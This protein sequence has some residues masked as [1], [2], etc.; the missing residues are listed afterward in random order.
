MHVHCFTV[1]LAIL[2][3]LSLAASTYG[4]DVIFEKDIEYAQ[5]GGESLKLNLARP[6][7]S[8]GALPAVL[9]IHGGGFRAGTRE[10]YDAICKK[11][12]S[13][14]YVAATIEYRLA[15]KHPFP[16]AMHD[17]RAAVRWLRA[18]AA[19][20]HIDPTRIGAMGGSAGGNLALMLGVTGEVANFEGE[21]GDL[22]HSARVACVADYFGPSDVSKSYGKSVDAAEV[23]PLYLGGNAQQEPRRHVLSSPLYWVTPYAAPTLILHGTED[24]YVAF[25]QAQWMYDRLRGA[26]VHAELLKLEGAGHGFK[27]EDAV[28]ADE[29][30][31]KFFD[32]HLRGK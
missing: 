10:G 9:C 6:S 29:A 26:H 2:L 24:K 31:F 27:G 18:H 11:L 7:E 21:S 19:K 5:A 28:R 3:A 20:Y 14:G 4:G 23:L 25:E 30:M 16:A 22:S 32:A 8:T 12:A 17:C 13:R 1:A 15:P